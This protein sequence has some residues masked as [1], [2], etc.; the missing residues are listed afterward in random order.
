MIKS[1]HSF[2]ILSASAA[3]AGTVSAVA[4]ELPPLEQAY[5]EHTNRIMVSVRFGL[6]VRAK[7]SGVGVPGGSPNG[8][9]DGYV[10][11]ANPPNL[12]P[13]PNYSTYWGYNNDS[14]LIGTPGNYTG[15]AFHTPTAAAGSSSDG[16]DD[17]RVGFEVSY[18]RQLFEKKDWHNLRF[19][20]EA[21][22]NYMR[23]SA[24]DRNTFGVNVSE[25]DYNFPI[26]LPGPFQHNDNNQPGNPALHVPGTPQASTLGS[27]SVVDNFDGDLWGGRLGPYVELP[28]TNGI[29][30]RLSGGLAVGWLQGDESWSETVTGLGSASGGGSDSSFLWGFY[31]S[32]DAAYQINR[33]WGVDV[34]VQYQDLGIYSHSFG[35]RVVELDL[36]E[37]IFFNVGVSYSF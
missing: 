32:L 11:T 8:Y 25:T 12:S 27:L 3:L 20:V 1:N 35:G 22:V 6:N 9:Y 18:L 28:F 23:V 14:Q 5:M 13:N 2:A 19:G 29:N 10:V 36:S 24:S 34:G 4:S 33:R 37:S 17:P 26:T 15:V 7:F 16:G 31:I 21:A 30:V